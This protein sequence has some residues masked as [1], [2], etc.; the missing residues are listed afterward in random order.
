M[1]GSQ[2]RCHSRRKGYAHLHDR[3][4]GASDSGRAATTLGQARPR[5]GTP[6]P[7]AR[8][9]GASLRP[10]SAGPAAA[11]RPLGGPMASLAGL[12]AAVRSRCCRPIALLPPTRCARHG[13]EPRPNASR[14]P[15][16]ADTGGPVRHWPASRSWTA[17]QA[18]RRSPTFASTT[19]HKLWKRP[20][21]AATS[22]A[23][24]NAVPLSA[25]RKTCRKAA[26]TT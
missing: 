6:P 20:G 9:A 21:N 5:P 4:L 26:L 13:R 10:I 11:S 24:A 17:C 2:H 12:L 22:P 3:C 25:C 19:R 8:R 14:S 1:T 15:A 7:A 18:A 23:S 16:A